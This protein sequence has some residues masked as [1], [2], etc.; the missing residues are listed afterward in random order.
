MAVP[1]ALTC[2]KCGKVIG[3]VVRPES[4]K[5]V[6]LEITAVCPN[7][8]DVVSEATGIAPSDHENWNKLIKELGV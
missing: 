5:L 7:C 6:P 8:L 3:M 4:D 2:K 1:L